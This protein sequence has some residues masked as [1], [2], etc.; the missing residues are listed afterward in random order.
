MSIFSKLG[1][2][3]LMFF[4]SLAASSWSTPLP[5][6][7]NCM[8]RW[9]CDIGVD[10]SSADRYAD[11][12]KQEDVDQ[13]TLEQMTLVQLETVGVTSFGHM[14]L[15]YN[16]VRNGVFPCGRGGTCDISGGRAD[17]ACSCLDGF[18]GAQCED[19]TS[20]GQDV[21]ENGGLCSEGNGVVSCQ[22][23]QA[24]SGQWCQQDVCASSPCQNGGSCSHD[25]QTGYSCS[26]PLGFR[27]TNCETAW[28]S[29][30]SY[31]QNLRTLYTT[32]AKVIVLERKVKDQNEKVASYH[33]PHFFAK[34]LELNNL[35]DVAKVKLFTIEE[36]EFTAILSPDTLSIISLSSSLSSS[37]LL[38][39]TLPVSDAHS[40]QVFEI[41]G[42]YYIAVAQYDAGGSLLFKWNTA[43]RNFEIAQ[44][45]LTVQAVDVDFV[46]IENRGRFLAFSQNGGVS[47]VI[48]VWLPTL[49]HFDHYQ[50]LPTVNATE[51]SFVSTRNSTFLTVAS[52]SGNM[53]M[54][55]LWNGTYFETFQ[56]IES[57]STCSGD[58]YTFAIG[59]ALFTVSISS[60]ANSESVIYR[61]ENSH[62]VKH[63]TI[64]T[65]RG[66]LVQYMAINGGH[67]LA[68]TNPLQENS[69]RVYKLSGTIFE[70]FQVL[71]SP[72]GV[73]AMEVSSC[74][75]NRYCL[76]VANSESALVYGW[77]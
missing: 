61:V 66:S 7:Q 18:A 62:Y 76:A 15:V 37:S 28:L 75:E 46:H 59:N 42:C 41:N 16:S 58:F 17:F 63:T 4:G 73:A 30:G 10:S 34:R 13:L 72:S 29:E 57:C 27:G 3:L 23:L 64:P 22:C 55:F 53:G 6:T 40:L 47:S 35:R 44:E 25:G 48:Y 51:L 1:V 77:Q 32:L 39:Q 52:N 24:F 26:C 11:I 5:N 9:L 49:G 20:C 2:G 67:F 68:V 45:F 56:E 36:D 8:H 74:G 33:E 21:C 14:T 69:T 19:V 50:F 54:V 31:Q 60:Q 12:F 43:A 70:P 71:E 65:S 38:I